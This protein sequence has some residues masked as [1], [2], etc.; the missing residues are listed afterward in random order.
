MTVTQAPADASGR[1]RVDSGVTRQ[2]ATPWSSTALDIRVRIPENLLLRG[3]DI[4]RDSAAAGLGDISIVVGGDFRVQK[5]R[6]RPTALVGTI[7]TVRGSY[8]S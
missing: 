6:R 5:E 8:G 7:T 2:P 4:R 1:R 3:Q